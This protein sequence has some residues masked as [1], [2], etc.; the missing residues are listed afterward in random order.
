MDALLNGFVGEDGFFS[1]SK[2]LINFVSLSFEHTPNTY[3]GKGFLDEST[4]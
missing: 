3:L 2:T 4:Y 1:D